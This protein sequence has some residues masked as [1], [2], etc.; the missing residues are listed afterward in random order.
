MEL[1][2]DPE[3]SQSKQQGRAAYSS[4]VSTRPLELSHPSIPGHPAPG[5]LGAKW[6]V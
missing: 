4:L 6:S 1:P 2:N 3:I 5:S